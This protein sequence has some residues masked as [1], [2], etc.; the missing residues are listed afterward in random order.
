MLTGDRATGRGR[1]LT[2]L[3]LAGLMFAAAAGT[4]RPAHAA[5]DDPQVRLRAETSQAHDVAKGD[6]VTV[7]VLSSGVDPRVRPRSGVLRQGTDL[8]HLPHPQRI[9][10]TLL[11]TLIGGDR[12]VPGLPALAPGV[13][14][15]P[16]RIFPEVGDHGE[17]DWRENT[18]FCE[19]ITRGIRYAVDHGAGVVLVGDAC[20]DGTSGDMEAA[21]ERARRRNV[22]VVAPNEPIGYGDPPPMP[23]SL[24]GVIGVGT[25][26]KDGTRWPKYSLKSSVTMVSAPGTATTAVGPDGRSGWTFSGS[27]PATAWVAATAALVR[28]KFPRLTPSQVAQAIAVSAHHPEGGYN[29]DVG[30]GVV[31]PV[32]ALSAAK[33]FERRPVSPTG[34]GVGDDAHFSGRRGT[35]DAAGHDPALPAGLGGLVLV[36]AG[37]LAAAALRLRAAR[38]DAKAVQAYPWISAT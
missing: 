10:G 15:L 19:V 22:V 25:L 31:N 30:F 6:G 37:A 23:A 35:I 2:T 17:D 18:N 8:V 11:A 29:A 32:Q 27:E 14:V 26:A 36:S 4:P 7:A 1:R 16:V 28:S 5:S 33:D 21:L 38:R 34:T 13:D 20:W 9:E 12:S 3:A 24:P